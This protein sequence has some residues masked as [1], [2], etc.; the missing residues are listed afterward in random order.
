MP[1]E[2]KFVLSMELQTPHIFPH[3]PLPNIC[4]V[5]AGLQ[6]FFE[7]QM[8]GTMCEVSTS[9]DFLSVCSPA[10]LPYL[11]GVEKSGE[12]FPLCF[13]YGIGSEHLLGLVLY[14]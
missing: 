4:V 3:I 1:L 2:I 14:V 7:L 11:L 9:F 6:M 5:G 10:Y 13:P 8:R 12:K